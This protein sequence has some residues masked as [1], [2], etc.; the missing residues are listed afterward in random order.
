MQN[1]VKICKIL[2]IR[3]KCKVL[4]NDFTKLLQLFV[5]MKNSVGLDSE[6][7]PQLG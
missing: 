3:L 2:L 6:F 4:S 1:S 7:V 5:F